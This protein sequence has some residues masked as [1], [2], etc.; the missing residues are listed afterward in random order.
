MTTHEKCEAILR[1]MVELANRGT[2]VT[3]EEDFGD[4]TLTIYVGS[5]H[6]HVGIPGD[7]GSF[8]LLVNNLYNSLHGGPGLSWVD[9]SKRERSVGVSDASERG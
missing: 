8:D 6:T 2:P 3:L 9:E 4:W 7:D 5:S 1:K